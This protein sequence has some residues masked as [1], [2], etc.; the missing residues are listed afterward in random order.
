[1]SLIR[2]ALAAPSQ[3][4]NDFAKNFY[5]RV[6]DRIVNAGD[7]DGNVHLLN[8]LTRRVALVPCSITNWGGLAFSADGKMLAAHA[9]DNPVISLFTIEYQGS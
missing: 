1:M 4:G 6:V 7:T 8:L 5:S 9:A 3:F 2:K